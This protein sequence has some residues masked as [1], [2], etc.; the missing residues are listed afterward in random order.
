MLE[1]GSNLKEIRL[2]LKEKIG[3]IHSS[4]ETESIIKIIF[5]HSG[6]DYMDSFSHPDITSNPEIISQI[7]EI[8]DEIAN[9]RPIQYILGYTIFYELKLLVNSKVLIPRPETEELVDR[10][11]K[12][13]HKA[14]PSVLDIGTGSGCIAIALKTH[15]PD[16]ELHAIDM[17]PEALSVAKKNAENN[18]AAIHFMQVDFLDNPAEV[19][20]LKVDII[21]SNPPYVTH[22]EK[23][24]MEP[25]VLENEPWHALFVDDSNPLLFYRA[26]ADY[27]GE[28]LNKRGDIWLEINEKYGVEIKNLFKEKGFSDC[29]LFKDLQGKER[30]FHVKAT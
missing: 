20:N 3:E 5:D 19:L 9:N 2:F 30:I 28:F 24:V 13:S 1:S 15:L 21:V 4:Q 12:S 7:K 17:F 11:I 6:L 18:S 16:A 29:E 25:N 22:S 8:V 26:I 10:I 27:A 23:E 14:H